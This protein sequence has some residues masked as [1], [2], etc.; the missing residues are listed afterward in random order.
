M[1][2]LP[3]DRLRA[4]LALARQSVLSSRREALPP[5]LCTA[6][7]EGMSLSCRRDQVALRYTAKG[8]FSQARLVLPGAA[9]AELEAVT[10]DTIRLG[11]VS[12]FQARA[13]WR[14]G[15]TERVLAFDTALVSSLPPAPEPAAGSVI[16]PDG[17]LGA[18][19]EAARTCSR[20]VGNHALTMV[21]LRGRDGS[22]VGTD[23]RQ[24]LVQNGTPLPWKDDLL[25]PA[26]P[27]YG[28]REWRGQRQVRLGREGMRVTLEV[29][30]WLL[31]LEAEPGTRYPDID[32]VVP[33]AGAVTTT[34]H[35]GAEDAAELLKALPQLPGRDEPDAPVTLE[36]GKRVLIRAGGQELPLSRS[37]V[38]GRPAR[39]LTNRRPL[40]RALRL[41]VRS[42][43]VTAP[44][45]PVL[46]RDDKRLY[47]WMPLTPDGPPMK[48]RP[49]RRTMPP[50]ATPDPPPPDPADA[51][52]EAEV[53]RQ[54]LQDALARTSR[55]I[56]AL[57]QHRRQDRAVKAAVASLR[58]L[59][60]LEP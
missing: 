38:E 20:P 25:L 48:A 46:C 24:L 33:A 39:V 50:T 3:R 58:K 16:A 28:G 56:Q 9:L 1:L 29:G 40:L 54:Q 17:F 6:T 32:R 7:R 37:R 34:L 53:L 2:D 45:R 41:G 14:E 21:L 11:S 42:V 18:V 52:A 12:A 35:L 55:L 8:P 57:R 49:E 4:F 19:A 59:G 23:G 36:L 31:A 15:D 60:E 10:A 44:G 51:L 47:L 26:L 22:V 30:P 27:V 43:V 13:A 5:V